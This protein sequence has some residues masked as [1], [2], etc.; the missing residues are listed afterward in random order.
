MSQLPESSNFFSSV[1]HGLTKAEV[2]ALFQ[3]AGW[4][5]R[6]CSWTDYEVTCEWAE[7]V[8]EAD[9]PVLVHGLVANPQ[10]NVPRIAGLFDASGASYSAEWYNDS[11]TLVGE[12]RKETDR[13]K[14]EFTAAAEYVLKKNAELNRRLA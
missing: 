4:K 11:G 6:K 12:V 5:V 14:S 3:R 13:A 7:L 8:I 2:V 10:E 1:H 9:N